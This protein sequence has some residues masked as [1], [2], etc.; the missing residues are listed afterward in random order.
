MINICLKRAK[1]FL[2]E[3]IILIT[4]IANLY[5]LNLCYFFMTFNW[6]FIQDR[7]YE[8]KLK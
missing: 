6:T 2:G 7:V 3:K 1:I 5:K 8:F 4:I